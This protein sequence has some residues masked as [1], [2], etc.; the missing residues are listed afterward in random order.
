M[1]QTQKKHDNT[2]YG[3]L[4]LRVALGGLFLA[5]AALKIFVFTVPGFVGYFASL[6]LPAVMAYA[7]IAAE[8]AGGL[9]LILG[10]FAP[11]A[12]ALLAVEVL[13]TIVMVHGRN[14][15][16]FT[17]Q[18]GGWEFP[19]LWCVALI[20]VAVMGDGPGALWPARRVK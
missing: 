3:L 1:I 9:A 5:H 19:A 7:T 18:G 8:V 11:W 13:G 14:G 17:N 2:A 15:W 20:A 16:L 12:A 6:G 10:V 4:L